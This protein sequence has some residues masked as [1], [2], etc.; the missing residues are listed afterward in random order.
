MKTKNN[1]LLYPKDCRDSHP[2]QDRRMLISYRLHLQWVLFVFVFLGVLNA[3]SLC[4]NSPLHDPPKNS[5]GTDSGEGVQ[6][7]G[8][9]LG[10]V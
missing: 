6:D 7:L 1:S 3:G 8:P 2:P 5:T 9:D 4:L 10:W